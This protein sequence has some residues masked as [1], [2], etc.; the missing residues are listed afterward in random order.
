MRQENNMTT[1]PAMVFFRLALLATAL[2]VLAEEGPAQSFEAGHTE[3]TNF[4]PGG[5][6]YVNDSYGYLSVDGWDERAVEITIIKSTDRFYQPDRLDEAKRRV[7]QIQVMTEQR[8]DTELAITTIRASRHADW[9]PPLPATTKAGVNI[10]CQIHAPRDTRLVIHH[11]TGYVWVSDVTGE[12]EATSHTGDMIV[13]LP[14]P[15]VY[16][17]D[18]KTRMGSISSDFVGH[19]LKQFLVGSHF[20]REGEGPSRRIYLRMGRGSITIKQSPTPR[21]A[22]KLRE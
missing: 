5:I 16:S 9:A 3:R 17:I 12:I 19:G 4:S 1:K 7:E 14:V 8:S 10:E 15:A 13:M 6:I 18:A 11:D 21:S 2:S 20:L 22:T